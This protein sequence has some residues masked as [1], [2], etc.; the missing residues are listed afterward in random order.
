MNFQ[1]P[2][3]KK[4]RKDVIDQEDLHLTE[5]MLKIKHKIVIM[6][7]K[8]GVGKSTISANLAV[9]FA[10]ANRKVGILDCDI[11]GP[12]IPSLLGIKDKRPEMI[13]QRIIP[14]K[15][16]LDINVVSIDFFLP[17]ISSPV[18][19][20]GPLKMRAIKQ[21][22]T[23]V[24]WE[25][26][27]YLIIDLPPG[28]GDEPLSIMQFI[29][30]LDG[31][32]MITI[33]SNIS[34][35]VVRKAINMVRSMDTP[36]IGIIENMSGFLCPNCNKIYEIYGKGG[37]ELLS[38][39]FNINFLGKIPIDPLIAEYSDLG[40]SFLLE[41]TSTNCSKAMNSIIEMIIAI[42]E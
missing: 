6:S 30:D 4:T 37:G 26:L 20:R 3:E 31:I 17:D 24:A 23:D 27:D 5:N 19:W 15:G 29:D 22:L 33:P 14:V 12:S 35:H 34:Q 1:V 39:E 41:K 28:T 42:I 8:G 21:F 9:A 13:N 10:N 38:E 18:I 40:K 25:E 16:P 36:I 32:I 7:G 2:D 11:H